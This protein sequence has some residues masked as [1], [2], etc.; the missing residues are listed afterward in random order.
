M[1]PA[2]SWSPNYV[3]R[4]WLANTNGDT[5]VSDT[6]DASSLQR[7]SFFL[8]DTGKYGSY[9][10]GHTVSFPYK[11]FRQ[12]GQQDVFCCGRSSKPAG[13]HQTGPVQNRQLYRYHSAV[14]RHYGTA[15]TGTIGCCRKNRQRR[16][17]KICV[18]FQ[19]SSA[20]LYGD[21]ENLGRGG[22][23]TE[24][25]KPDGIP[26]TLVN[27]PQLP[28][29]GKSSSRYS[30]QHPTKNVLSGEMSVPPTRSFT[31]PKARR[32]WSTRCTP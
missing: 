5:L 21:G 25:S 27:D 15:G 31:C 26:V 16:Y 9:S 30:I 8:V 3:L 17:R 18:R 24:F 2:G 4:F 20:E 12:Y 28:Q 32:N 1:N 6:A 11:A 19:Y 14:A 22:V 7:F 13:R 10:F 23:F 29:N